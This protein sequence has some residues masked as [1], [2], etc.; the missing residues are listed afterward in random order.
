MIGAAAAVLIFRLPGLLLAEHGVRAKAI[1]GS[2]CALVG[3]AA[4]NDGPR[5]SRATIAWV[6]MVSRRC[7]ETCAA[8]PAVSVQDSGMQVANC[9]EAPLCVLQLLTRRCFERHITSVP[10]CT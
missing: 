1:L 8:E 10:V 4:A 9:A 2:A 3:V 6:T 7:W 5:T